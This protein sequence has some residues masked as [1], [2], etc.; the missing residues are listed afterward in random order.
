MSDEISAFE[1]DEIK[2]NTNIS[3]I[4]KRGMGKTY[5]IKNI[6]H[7]LKTIHNSKIII[8]S[9]KE[10]CGTEYDNVYA[11]IYRNRNDLLNMKECITPNTILILDDCI[12]MNNSSFCER[13]IPMLRETPCRNLIIL[14]QMSF[15]IGTIYYDIIMTFRESSYIHIKKIYDKYVDQN[16]YSF[17]K[18]TAIMSEHTRKYGCLV[19]QDDQPIKKYKAENPQTYWSDY[20]AAG[21]YYDKLDKLINKINNGHSEY[22]QIH[23]DLHNMLRCKLDDITHTCVIL[24]CMNLTTKNDIWLP[25]ELKSEILMHCINQLLKKN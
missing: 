24:L 11:H 12:P 14:Q 16:I 3:I 13:F 4:G 18:F 20:R 2:P 23:G 8:V 22:H 21:L 1:I 17:D 25:S 10:I 6:I 9:P 19:I 15:A 5:L 7:I